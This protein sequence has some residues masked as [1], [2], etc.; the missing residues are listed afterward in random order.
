M[1]AAPH[2]EFHRQTASPDEASLAPASSGA[3]A[4]DNARGALRL[5]GHCACGGG[6][7]HCVDAGAAT[8]AQTA[9]K[10]EAAGGEP[11]T[12]EPEGAAAATGLEG[13]AD[14][15]VIA[16]GPGPGP[17][18]APGPAAPAPAPAPAPAAPAKPAKKTVTVNVSKL[19]GSSRA[20][21]VTD[22]SKIFEDA[23][24]LS[25]TTGTVETVNKKDS[26]A[27]IGTDLIL[28][29]YSSPGS[30]TAEETALTKRN[31]K[32]DTITVYLVKALSAGSHG[33]AFWA[34][35][36]PSTPASVVIKNGDSP[37]VAGKP[38]AHELGHVLLDSGDH[39]GDKTNLMSYDHTGVGLDA[40][41]VTK[42]RSSPFA[43]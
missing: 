39:S 15:D 30:P 26:E 29:E 36:F 22:A 41:R 11:P 20:T 43:K 33:E 34:A 9:G 8:A 16:M 10:V 27:L 6:C 28:E 23:A 31:R 3:F 24:S 13:F 18:P 37:F 7:P 42:V 12:E 40:T 4:T 25:V 35:D 2:Y 32:K 21:S 17:G 1:F 5:S 19:E 14:S 38:L